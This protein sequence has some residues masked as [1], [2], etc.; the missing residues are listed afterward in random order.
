MLRPHRL[1]WIDRPV[2]VAQ[3]AMDV[4]GSGQTPRFTPLIPGARFTLLPASG[5]AAQSDTP[6]TIIDLVQK[7]AD[8]AA[9]P[10]IAV[11]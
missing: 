8:R 5:H 7:V 2:I 11:A 6:Q 1:D 3:G 4:V 10:S 9:R